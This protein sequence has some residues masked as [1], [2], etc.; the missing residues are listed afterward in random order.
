MNQDDARF[1]DNDVRPNCNPIQ[2]GPAFHIYGHK[3]DTCDTILHHMREVNTSYFFQEAPLTVFCPELFD[4]FI[5]IR[6]EIKGL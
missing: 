2:F 5:V 6:F 1:G 4:Y 3:Q